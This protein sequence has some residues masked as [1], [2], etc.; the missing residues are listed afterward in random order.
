MDNDYLNLN[1]LKE[2]VDLLEDGYSVENW[3]S[4]L[5]IS[6]PLIMP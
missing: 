1:I 3:L 4:K 2:F 5:N 6:N